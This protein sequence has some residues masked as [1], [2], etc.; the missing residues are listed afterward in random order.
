MGL[1]E[2]MLGLTIAVIVVA[3][4]AIPSISSI[5][6]LDQNT[7][8]NETFNATADP[9]TYTV[10]DAAGSDF[11][12]LAS[13]TCYSDAGSTALA[14]SACN[15]TD[16]EAGTVKL[17][18]TVDAGD[19]AVDYTWNPENYVQNDTSRLVLGFVVVGAAVGLL[20]AA[21]SFGR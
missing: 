3:G 8:I 12:Q 2:N 19:E 18:T 15:I 7:V 11:T 4:V 16:A 17:S 1:L 9:F 5:L 21:F 13:V 14:D 10:G 6:V 20:M